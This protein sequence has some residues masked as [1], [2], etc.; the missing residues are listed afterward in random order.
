MLSIDSHFFLLL[1]FVVVIATLHILVILPYVR[2]IALNAWY[3]RQKIAWFDG[4]TI[5]SNLSDFIAARYVSVGGG[6]GALAPLKCST[7]LHLFPFTDRG[8]ALA[9]AA[10]PGDPWTIQRYKFIPYARLK[11]L[12]FKEYVQ[13]CLEDVNDWRKLFRTPGG[14][15]DKKRSRV[16]ALKRYTYDVSF[17]SADDSS[18]L[19]PTTLEESL[20]RFQLLDT[21][22]KRLTFTFRDTLLNK[23]YRFVLNG[24]KLSIFA[25]PSTN[26]MD[27]KA[28]IDKRLPE[29]W[30]DRMATKK[31][32]IVLFARGGD[33]DYDDED[34]TNPCWDA[35][36]NR[37]R[38]GK[39]PVNLDQFSTIYLRGLQR[40]TTDD[41][42]QDPNVR[43]YLQ[44]MFWRCTYDV[45]ANQAGGGASSGVGG[46]VDSNKNNGENNDGSGSGGGG[47]GKKVKTSRYASEFTIVNKNSILNNTLLTLNLCVDGKKFNGKTCR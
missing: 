34:V 41:E 28:E 21:P 39:H 35:K 45:S 20:Q 10:K 42:R 13:E 22:P 7:Y 29:L 8:Q 5:N 36:Y 17:S 6:D 24:Y 16:S 33:I 25:S 43:E 38:I 2:K 26:T 37:F 30:L 31:A 4:D 47:G 19:P 40:V 44:K 9:I 23:E 1:I 12:R 32:E 27:S 14:D 18:S 11:D 3:S 15:R 46:G